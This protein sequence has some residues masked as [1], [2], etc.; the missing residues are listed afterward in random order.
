MHRNC[1]FNT[2]GNLSLMSRSDRRE[3]IFRNPL[4]AKPTSMF[5]TLS[6]FKNQTGEAIFQATRHG[7]FI[8]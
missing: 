1:E 3:E 5:V 6:K 8:R 7:R 2:R 4:P